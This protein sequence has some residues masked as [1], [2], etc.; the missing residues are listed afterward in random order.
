MVKK[1]EGL[2]KIILILIIIAVI[3]ITI[4]SAIYIIDKIGAAHIS[5]NYASCIVSCAEIMDNCLGADCRDAKDNK[6]PCDCDSYVRQCM[7]WCYGTPSK[8]AASAS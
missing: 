2:P 3:L 6:I 1:R 4:A 5:G 8:T 7:N